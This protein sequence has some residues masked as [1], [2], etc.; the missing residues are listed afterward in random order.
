MNNIYTYHFIVI[1]LSIVGLNCDLFPSDNTLLI[2]TA[3]L[4]PDDD[5][6][7]LPMKLDTIRQWNKNITF[8]FYRPQGFDVVEIKYNDSITV[9]KNA[10]LNKYNENQVFIDKYK[11]VNPLDL[12]D[13]IRDKLNSL[14]NQNTE[15][16]KEISSLPDAKNEQIRLDFRLIVLDPTNGL[17]DL[18]FIVGGHYVKRMMIHKWFYVAIF[19]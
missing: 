9:Y 2:C 1:L 15:G 6:L 8:Q 7:C 18:Y 10:L 16:L 5:I 13:A 4:L 19:E 12:T 17:N 14:I 11:D 3:V